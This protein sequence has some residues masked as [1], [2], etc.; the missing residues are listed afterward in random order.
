[1]RCNVGVAG[2]EVWVDVK[3]DWNYVNGLKRR[4]EE[5]LDAIH[6]M[7]TKFRQ[8]AYLWEEVPQREK[9]LEA[10]WKELK[11]IQGDLDSYFKK[12][13][14]LQAEF[15][16]AAEV[17]EAE[18]LAT[19]GGFGGSGKTARKKANGHDSRAK[20]AERSEQSRKIRTMMQSASGKKKG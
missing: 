10:L 14:K 13:L 16:V 4:K 17:R 8:R 9:E 6:C 12:D 20:K 19:V 11:E 3:I 1:M 2:A 18:R 15:K 7:R 5:V